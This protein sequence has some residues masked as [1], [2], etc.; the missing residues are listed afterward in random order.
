M[1]MPKGHFDFETNADD[2]YNSDNMFG[3][4]QSNTMSY[5][6]LFSHYIVDI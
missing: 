4:P 6:P 5:P 3:F 1:L 2:Y